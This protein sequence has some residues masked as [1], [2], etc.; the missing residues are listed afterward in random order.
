METNFGE[1]LRVHID[2]IGFWLSDIIGS[3]LNSFENVCID[4]VGSN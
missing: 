1:I 2:L 3:N 4:G